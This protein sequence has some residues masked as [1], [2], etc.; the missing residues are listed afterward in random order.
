MSILQRKRILFGITG[1]VAAYKSIDLIRRLKEDGAEI[2]CILTRS[3]QKFVTPLLIESA[4][5][6]KVYTDMFDEPLSHINLPKSADLFVIAPA[7]ANIIGKFST[8]IADDLLSTIYLAYNSKIVIAPAMN[9]RMYENKT[10]QRNI[11]F[12]SEEGILFVEPE[13]GPLACGETGKGRMA[14]SE[15]I[16]ETIRSCFYK[17]D[18]KDKKIVVTAGPTREYIDPVRFISN[19]S[20]GKMGYAIA[21]SAKR[22]GGRVTLISGP[23]HIHRPCNIPIINVENAEDMYRAVIEHTEDAHILIMSAA[24]S[25]YKPE[26]FNDSKLEKADKLTLEISQTVDIL[27]SIIN[28]RKNLFKV[29]FSAQTDG[30]LNKAR[31]KLT[32]KGLDIIIFNNVS[33]PFAGFDVDT[34]KVTI[35]TKTGGEIDM[36]VLKKDTLADNIWDCILNDYEQRH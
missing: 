23:A 14:R 27:K 17:Q 20:S 1:S 18:L 15:M 25:D 16:L 35:I 7:T 22:R 5:G 34:N 13:E 26:K 32:R 21:Q 33:E 31:E 3:A 11:R 10:V 8:G 36:P 30:D 19:R 12:L 29:G 9:H 24:V 2:D 28:S 6:V 4:C